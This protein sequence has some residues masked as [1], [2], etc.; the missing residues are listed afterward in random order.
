MNKQTEIEILK[1]TAQRL[2]KESYCGAWMESIIPEI[3]RDITSD[4]PPTPTPAGTREQHE[5]IIDQAKRQAAKIIEA[6]QLEREAARKE[7]R[8]IREAA[9]IYLHNLA[10]NL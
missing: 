1:D 7:A 3:E 4:M 5:R 2:G 8:E 6:A 9:K 10:R